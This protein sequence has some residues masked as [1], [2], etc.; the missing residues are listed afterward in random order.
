[1]LYYNI[2]SISFI[3]YKRKS[4]D[5][6]V[7]YAD[8]L[9]GL[10]Q[11]QARPEPLGV[12]ERGQPHEATAFF[13]KLMTAQFRVAGLVRKVSA[14]ED[15]EAILGDTVAEPLLIDPFYK[16]WVLDMAAVCNLF[17]D[18]LGS[19][20]VCFWLGTRRGCRRFHV[21][22]VPIRLLVTY[23]GQG[24]EWLPDEAADRLAFAN[25]AS[26]DLI[27]KDVRARHFMNTWSVAI[28]RGGANGLLH[29][30]PDD[31][32]GGQSILMRLDHPSYWFDVLQDQ[33]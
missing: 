25:G 11:F 30:T 8:S 33:P 12:I 5:M 23:A 26:N 21:D 10:T 27:V 9:S 16:R 20:S 17:C 3:W 13:A 28:F 29:R 22:Q 18:V 6:N 1:M 4:E 7:F 15:I 14:R 19:K 32:M 2:F 31:A 24:T